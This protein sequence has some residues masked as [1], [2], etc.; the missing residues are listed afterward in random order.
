MRVFVPTTVVIVHYRYT[1]SLAS[2][3]DYFDHWGTS[4]QNAVPWTG[5][6]PMTPDGRD[7]HHRSLDSPS[8]CHC[9]HRPCDAGHNPRPPSPESWSLAVYSAEASR[10]MPACSDQTA[11][12]GLFGASGPQPAD[13]VEVCS[14]DS[15]GRNRIS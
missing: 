5:L 8:E 4:P 11:S 2:A 3:A 7:A 12:V 6:R 15:F 1:G 9:R 14:H 13:V 10:P